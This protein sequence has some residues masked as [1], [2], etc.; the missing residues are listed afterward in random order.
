MADSSGQPLAHFERLQSELVRTVLAEG[1]E[2]MRTGTLVVLPS[3]TFPT[4]ELRKI[5]GIQFYEERMMYALLLLRDPELRIV[6]VTSI[7]VDPEIVDYYLRFIPEVPD[8]RDRLTMISVGDPAPSALTAKVLASDDTLQEIRAAIRPGRG[9]VF[10]FNVTRLEAVFAQEI[11]L[12]LFGPHPDLVGLGSKSGS[13][14]V[15]KAAGVPVLPGCEDL[16]SLTEVEEAIQEISKGQRDADAVVVKLNYGFS[17]QGNAII[18]LRTLRLPLQETPTVFC[19]SEESWASFEAKIK[20][21]G[22]IVEELLRAP[23]VA[24]PSVQLRIAPGGAI[25]ILST[26]D[27]ILGGPDDQVYLGCRFPAFAHYRRQILDLALEAAKVLAAEG[28]FGS[29]GI[30]FIGTPTDGGW[31]MYLSEINLRLGGTTHPFRMA[32][33]VTG[34]EYEFSTGELRAD[35]EAKSYVAT[36]N[37]KSERLVGMTPGE[38][39]GVLRENGLEYDARSRTGA[40]LHL[41]GALEAHGK[42]G[43]LCIANSYEAA[44]DLYENVVAALDVGRG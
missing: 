37:L 27:Q 40:T 32:S 26:H 11:G 4:E 43:S 25:E 10:P 15:A 44:E 16:R 28:V 21:D 2:S 13:R 38:A 35:G 14:R 12:P 30:D 33:L 24:S 17:G 22:A 34:G 3:I 41:L 1:P 6:Y 7:E 8:A 39:I 36:D 31:T 18:D 23:V 5:I 19:A 9:Y 29:F 42:I 20:A